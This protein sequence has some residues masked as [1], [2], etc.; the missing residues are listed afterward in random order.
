MGV[1][2]RG[3]KEIMGASG[4]QREELEMVDPALIERVRAGAY[5]VDPHAVAGAMLE[6][7]RD[8]ARLS[9][10]LVAGER[11]GAAGGVAEGGPLARGDAA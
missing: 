10:M 7:R 4:D 5:V 2:V 9:R 11:N 1:P 3:F 8:A 6:R